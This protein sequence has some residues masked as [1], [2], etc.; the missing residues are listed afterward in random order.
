MVDENMNTE[1]LAQPA[2]P[3][4]FRSKPAWQRMIVM[5]GGII[6]N[7]VLGVFIF[8]MMSYYYGE[9]FTKNESIK[10]GVVASTLAKEVGF[11][12]GDKLLSVNGKPIIHFRKSIW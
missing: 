8:A 7:V 4:E 3:W 12:T 5:L 11:E 9:R 1:Q 2:E 10:N 6:F